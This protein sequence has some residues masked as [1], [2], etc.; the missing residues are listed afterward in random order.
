MSSKNVLLR[1]KAIRLT[2]AGR[3]YVAGEGEP[4]SVTADLVGSWSRGISVGPL[5]DVQPE[6]VRWA[7]RQRE[8]LAEH[9][10]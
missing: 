8:K 6:G 1:S 7:V 3:H 10:L 2:V 9:E 4:L 5:S